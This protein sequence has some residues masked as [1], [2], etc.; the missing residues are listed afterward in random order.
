M[1]KQLL[2]EEFLRMQKLAGVITESQFNQKKKLVENQ[3]NEFDMDQFSFG[4]TPKPPAASFMNK[5]NPVPPANEE[6][7]K[8]LTGKTPVRIWADSDDTVGNYLITT[9]GNKY[10]LHNSR[11]NYKKFETFNSEE[12]AKKQVK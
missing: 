7:F 5:W 4:N 9:D 3:I 6:N 12:D 11:D 1:K 10:Y 2:S 8:K